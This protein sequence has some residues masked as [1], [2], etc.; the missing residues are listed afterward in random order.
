MDAK[1][2]RR[3]V[4]FWTPVFYIVHNSPYTY[5]EFIDLFIHPAMSLLMSSPP[6]RLTDEMKRI[7][8][9]SKVY[10]IVDWYYYQHH[11]VIRIYGCEL[12][13]YRLPI[14]VPMGLFALE[15]FRQFGNAD[16]LHFQSKNK[17]SQLK[18]RSQLGPFLYNRKE[19]GWKEANSILEALRLQTSFEWIP[20]DPNHFVSLRRIKYKLGSYSHMRQP[21]IERYANTLSW[22]EG[23]PGKKVPLK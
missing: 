15:Y 21:E 2:E 10:S 20:Y 8:Q 7:L 9:M 17:K 12:L 16:Y 22:E 14:Y 5:C 18:V 23:T 6:P 1:V 19:E 11:T 3:S 4:I 13:A